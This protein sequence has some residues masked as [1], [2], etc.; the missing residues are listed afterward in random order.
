MHSTLAVCSSCRLIHSEKIL[1][2]QKTEV[3]NF[4]LA[5]AT[6]AFYSRP[7]RSKNCQANSVKVL[8]QLLG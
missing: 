4:P 8:V 7:Q 5:Q 2:H 3:Q 1:K 6:S